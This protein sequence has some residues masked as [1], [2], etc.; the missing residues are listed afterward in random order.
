MTNA[1]IQIKVKEYLN[2]LSSNDFQNIRCWQIA[3]AFNSYQSEWCR[4]NLHGANSSKEGDSESLSRLDDFQHLVKKT[5]PLNFKD[6]GE[7]FQTDISMWPTDYFRYERIG[8]TVTNDCCSSPKRMVVYLCEEANID[9]FLNDS[10]RKPG[11][12]WGET[13]A[14]I[15]DGALNIYH[16][17]EF[18]IHECIFT[19]YRQPT[20][21][22]IA[23][24]VDT[25][26]QAIT[27]DVECEF[28]DDLIEVLVAGAAE[29]LAG[30]IEN[31]FQNQRL[32]QDVE[33]NN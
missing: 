30:N 33:K 27:T 24:C 23:G 12:K 5:P 6:K 28:S 9:I 13:F 11:Y 2:K 17:G 29:Q 25:N 32:N 3:N 18:K 19:Y 1:T 21:I 31:A 16:G 26:G 22:Q 15:N 14:T 10:Y 8:L 4:R 20:K 7:Y